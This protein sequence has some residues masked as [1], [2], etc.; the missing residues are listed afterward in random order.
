MTA[1]HG[2]EPDLLTEGKAIGGGIPVGAFGCSADVARRVFERR[3]AGYC[4][5]GG[6]GGTSRATRSPSRPCAPPWNTCSPPK[7]VRE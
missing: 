5:A 7:P 2:L 3:E 6:A 1:A 4:D